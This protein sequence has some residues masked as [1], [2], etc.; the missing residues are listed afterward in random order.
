VSQRNYVTAHL[1]SAG[2]PLIPD[3]SDDGQF[4]FFDYERRFEFSVSV[5]E[6][7]GIGTRWSVTISTD[8]EDD[9]S[10]AGL[11][12]LPNLPT[13][14]REGS[15]YVRWSP[16]TA[17]SAADSPRRISDWVVGTISNAAERLRLSKTPPAE[18]VAEV[19]EVASE[20]PAPEQAE[21][22]H[23]T[24]S[25]AQFNEREIKELLSAV[26]GASS[27]PSGTDHAH[28]RAEDPGFS[29]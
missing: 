26:A 22:T 12:R 2:V 28:R 5:G 16:F 23:G 19:D 25:A 29:P 18:E 9:E 13:S 7:P 17:D 11:K 10:L 3:Q 20:T 14:R 27:Y 15:S 24:D 4:S 1:R 21:E 8:A 6:I